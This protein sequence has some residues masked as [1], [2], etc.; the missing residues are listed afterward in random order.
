MKTIEERTKA[1]LAESDGILLAR[2]PGVKIKH[3]PE[4]VKLCR[5][6]A[7]DEHRMEQ[8]IEDVNRRAREKGIAVE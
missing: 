8:W 3:S 4:L 6:L 1:F 5:E 7:E 2:S